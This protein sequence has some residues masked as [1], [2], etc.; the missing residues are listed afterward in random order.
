VTEQVAFTF[1]DFAVCNPR[2]AGH[3]APAPRSAWSEGMIPAHQWLASPPTDPSTGVPFVLAVDDGDLLC[4]LVVDDRLIRAAQRCRDGW[5]R[6]QELAGVHDSRA[7]KLL[8]RERQAWEEQHR[9]AIAATA[10]A[11]PVESAKAAEPAATAC[12]PAIEAE[13]VRNP[14]EA[15]VETLRCSTCNECT[16]AFPRLFAYNENQQAYI[17]DLKAGTYRQLVEAAESCQVSVIHPGKPR[18]PDEPG[19]D[20][21][22]ERAKPFL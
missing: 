20:E 5:H 7:E 13:P 11:T 4:R 12:T 9:Q 21:L 15:Y 22:I 6:L 18:D 2:C 3:F 8:A 1:L 16:T 17:K 19:L 10:V 14:D